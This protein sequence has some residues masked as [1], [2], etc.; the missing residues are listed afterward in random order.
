MKN[1]F[2]RI[3]IILIIGLLIIFLPFI[4][5]N[6]YI[7]Y[8]L[9]L[10]MLYAVVVSNWDLTLG[11]LGSFN[12]AHLSFFLLG[13]Y[14]AGI[15]SVYFGF[16][17][18]LGIIIAALVAVI[19]SIIVSLPILRVKGYYV[20]LISFG[21]SQICKYLIMG[22]RKYT[23]GS[24]GLVLIPGLKIGNYSFSQDA[25]IGYYY[26]A[27]LLL[28]ISTIYLRK[29]IN[30]NF[31][32]SIIALRNSEMYAISRGIYPPRQLML[33]YIASA[34]F[35]GIAGSIY[36]YY[37]GAISPEL[38]SFGFLGTLLSM[39]LVGG[40]ITIYGPI[41]GAFIISFA[42]NYLV[43]LGPWR[44]LI[45]GLLLFFVVRFYPE[46]TWSFLEKVKKRGISF[47]NHKER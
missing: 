9:V 42:Y 31:G 25:K 16:S 43:G 6:D 35:T 29:L 12:F 23:G 38:F 28:T 33:A 19:A 32:R 26:V 46:G 20:I 45:I 4:I 24:M 1:N 13:A 22:L 47:Y 11:Y 36:V 7:T 15:S 40:I 17:P 2:K 27:L 3:S 37:L 21:F 44:F 39:L 5:Q 41:I 18:W 30:S 8:I 10:A 34:I 14:S